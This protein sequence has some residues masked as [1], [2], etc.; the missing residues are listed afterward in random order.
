MS[1]FQRLTGTRRRQ[2]KAR[3]GKRRL[4]FEGLEKRMLMALAAG[5]FDNDGIEDLAVG[6]PDEDYLSPDGL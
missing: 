5:D 2:S 6:V 4:R 1:Y 3:Y